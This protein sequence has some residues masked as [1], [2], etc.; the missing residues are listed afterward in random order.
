MEMRR[1][2]TKKASG[3]MV[4]TPPCFLP[5]LSLE[6]V[7]CLKAEGQ[8]NAILPSVF[9]LQADTYYLPKTPA[10]SSPRV[11]RFSHTVMPQA[12]MAAIFPWPV[13]LL[14]LMMAPAWPIRAARRRGES[15]DKTDHRFGDMLLDK[16]RGF[17]FGGSADFT[18]HDDAGWFRNLSGKH[19]GNR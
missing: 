15:G 2:F 17:F 16:C 19:P 13:P 14:P 5:S 8:V 7:G 9:S 1:S 12:F 3:K 10:Q 11:P 18:D 6:S 4:F